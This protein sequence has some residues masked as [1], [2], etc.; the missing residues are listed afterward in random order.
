MRDPCNGEADILPAN[1]F[2]LS[3]RLGKPYDGAMASREFLDVDPGS[4]RLPPSR[5]QGA[6]PFKLQVQIARFGRS[7][8]GMPALEVY[9]GSDAELMIFNGVTRA[10][11]V[12]KLLPGVL[13]RVEVLDD[14]R[15]PF[16]HLPTVK[17]QLP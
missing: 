16:G 8:V 14:L 10:T 15:I 11:R 9:R 13:I 12:A 7:T 17:D 6:D 1:S 5:P 2:A 3:D 4:L